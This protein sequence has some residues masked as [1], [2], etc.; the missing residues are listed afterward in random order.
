MPAGVRCRPGHVPVVVSTVA[1]LLP[2]VDA[3]ERLLRGAG[4]LPDAGLA[5]ALFCPA[6]FLFARAV[7]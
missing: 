3:T 7:V 1:E 4:Y 2:D 5:T 6:L